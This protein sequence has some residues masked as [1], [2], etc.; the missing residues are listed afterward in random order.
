[1]SVSE[2][3]S[4]APTSD[5]VPEVPPIP[6]SLYV[7]IPWCVSKCPY[8]DFNSHVAQEIDEPR[9]NR[10]YLAEIRRLAEE[11]VAHVLAKGL[12]TPDIMSDGMTEVNC[13]TMGDAGR[14]A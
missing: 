11:A 9:W 5:A 14:C 6:V 10:A 13:E 8:C 12:R 4:Q 7:H 3:M 1:M 2:V